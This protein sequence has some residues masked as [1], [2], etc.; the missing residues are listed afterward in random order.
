MTELCILLA[1]AVIVLS[2]NTVIQMHDIHTLEAHLDAIE[3]ELQC[4]SVTGTWAAPLPSDEI[5]RFR[6]VH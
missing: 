5:H 6:S 1:G 2:I 4:R 3:A